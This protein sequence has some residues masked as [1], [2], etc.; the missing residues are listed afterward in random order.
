VNRLLPQTR[1][2][3]VQ[4]VDDAGNVTKDGQQNVDE[5]IGAATTL[6]EDT[7]RRQNNG[8]DDLDNVTEKY[9]V[10]TRRRLRGLTTGT[11]GS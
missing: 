6:E 3:N 7:K 4:G 10:S 2:R 5:E 8:D 11:R 9:T 1:A